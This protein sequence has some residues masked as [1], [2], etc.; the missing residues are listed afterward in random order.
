VSPSAN[1]GSE[2][3]AASSASAALDGSDSSGLREAFTR[4]K[5]AG[6]QGLARQ[7]T[8]AASKLSV[9]SNTSLTQP[10]D[11]AARFRAAS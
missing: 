8:T 3:G 9:R 2:T 1:P 4:A 5:S 10:F 7:A 11:H 6:V